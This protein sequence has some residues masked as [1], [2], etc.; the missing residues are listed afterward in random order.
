MDHILHD[1]RGTAHDSCAGHLAQDVSTIGLQLCHDD[2]VIHYTRHLQMIAMY[3][4]MIGDPFSV[5]L[6]LFV[7]PRRDKFGNLMFERI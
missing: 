1:H 3:S 6:P 2:H 4:I 7:N 5:T